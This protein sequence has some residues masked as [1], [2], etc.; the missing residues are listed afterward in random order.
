MEVPDPADPMVGPTLPGGGSRAAQPAGLWSVRQPL[1]VGTGLP[2]PS[3]GR[4]PSRRAALPLAPRCE[5]IRG[6]S[7]APAMD[8]L[9]RSRS[10]RCRDARSP[11]GATLPSSLI[12]RARAWLLPRYV[13]GSA[14]TE[15]ASA[16][17][18]DQVL[19]PAPGWLLLSEVRE[20]L[21]A[22]L[23][24]TPLKRAPSLPAGRHRAVT[25][26][27]GGAGERPRSPG[28]A[29]SRRGSSACPGFT[30]ARFR[31]FQAPGSS[32]G[33]I[34]AASRSRRNSKAPPD[35]PRG[36][37]AATAAS[38]RVGEG[39]PRAACAGIA[40]RVGPRSATRR[41]GCRSEPARAGVVREAPRRTTRT[42]AESAGG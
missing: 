17:D 25:A 24:R 33:V 38:L 30:Q 12:G 7:D 31:G 20:R 13:G 39:V 1:G 37:I 15:L 34:A 35:P 28:A 29:V 26:A 41:S 36:Q 32:N 3:S 21:A 40:T 22:V 9:G 4:V 14:A 16:R 11:P 42:R 8:D 5:R 6:S 10:S 18:E 2:G 19:Q 23:G 27:A